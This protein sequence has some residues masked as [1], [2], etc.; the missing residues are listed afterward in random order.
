ML[1]TLFQYELS[2]VV[3]WVGSTLLT[4]LLCIYVRRAV[5][6]GRQNTDAET[7]RMRLLNRSVARIGG[8][9]SVSSATDYT[10]QLDS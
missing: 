6:M 10:R 5:V 4:A 8:L 2:G 7:E 3:S 1:H 9:Q